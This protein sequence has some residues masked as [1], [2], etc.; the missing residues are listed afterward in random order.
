MS[1]V[2]GRK[3]ISPWVWVGLGCG[4]IALLVVGLIVLLVVVGAKAVKEIAEDAT[5]TETAGVKVGAGL[6][7]RRD[8]CRSSDIGTVS[9]LIPGEAANQYKL[10]VVHNQG[11]GVLTQDGVYHPKVTFSQRAERAEAIDV[12]GDG[13]LEFLSR[14]SWGSEPCVFDFTG[15]VRW[16]AHGASGANDMAAGDTDGDGRLEFAVGYNGGGGVELL[17]SA[18]KRRWQKPAANVWAVTFV[19]TDGDGKPEVVHSNAGGECTVRN[20]ATGAEIS[21]RNTG[22][23]TYFSHFTKAPVGPAMEPRLVFTSRGHFNVVKPDGSD[24][25]SYTCSAASMVDN[26][27]RAASYAV[28]GKPGIA[29]VI[30]S[31][32]S[33]GALCWF[34]ASG[35]MLYYEELGQPAEAITT[36]VL[37]KGSGPALLVG[38]EGVVWAYEPGRA[39]AVAAP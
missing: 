35:S 12:E 18:G 38:A 9:Q 2:E 37:T 34:D 7:T 31:P 21:S 8:L 30:S 23:M 17:N 22:T 13:T 24:L 14:G 36:A 33:G 5:T 16:E 3:P 25:Q 11:Y 26:V 15:A 4:L 10:G 28:A 20:P 1:P 39:E 27:V 29:A 19:D 32:M 6:L